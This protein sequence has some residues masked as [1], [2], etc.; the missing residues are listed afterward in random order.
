M[1][2]IEARLY[3]LLFLRTYHLF[4]GGKKEGAQGLPGIL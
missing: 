2:K 1:G 4:D 3:F